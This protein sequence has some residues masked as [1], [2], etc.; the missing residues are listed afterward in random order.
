MESWTPW[1]K[2]T[3]VV[4]AADVETLHLDCEVLPASRA[5]KN[6]AAEQTRVA[7]RRVPF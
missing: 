1:G 3:T 4:A 2:T 5:L 7:Q 6:I